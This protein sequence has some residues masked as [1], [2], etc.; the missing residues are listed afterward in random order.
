MHPFV[1]W[2]QAPL[3][4]F[5]PSRYCDVTWRRF[6]CLIRIPKSAGI[7]ICPHNISLFDKSLM[8]GVHKEIS[9][10]FIASLRTWMSFITSGYLDGG[11]HLFVFQHCYDL[12]W[13]CD[14]LA[15]PKFENL[16]RFIDSAKPSPR[17]Q[18]GSTERQH[19]GVASR[20][21]APPLRT[22]PSTTVLITPSRCRAILGLSFGRLLPRA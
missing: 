4:T 15:A 14:A 13:N 7:L 8:F 2:H 5:R 22:G 6:S 18:K 3:W 1:T 19:G 16:F 20:R 12:G 10:S 9:N 11:L 17:S 21:L